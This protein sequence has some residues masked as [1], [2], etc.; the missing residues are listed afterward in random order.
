MNLVVQLHQ[1]IFFSWLFQSI[2]FIFP[3]HLCLVILIQ[4][5]SNSCRIC[6]GE[7]VMMLS[8]PILAWFPDP[9]TAVSVMN[10]YQDRNASWTST[11]G[12]CRIGGVDVCH[13]LSH[14]IVIIRSGVGVRAVSGADSGGETDRLVLQHI[15]LTPSLCTP[16]F[17]FT[18]FRYIDS[19]RAIYPGN[20]ITQTQ[21]F[22]Y[23]KSGFFS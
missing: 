9:G 17:C 19:K 13:P 4:I 12:Q 15:D 11:G 21:V 3:L 22:F 14:P 8:T 6:V 1:R 5:Q 7:M 23:L 2:G 18:D 20:F 10:P 16:G